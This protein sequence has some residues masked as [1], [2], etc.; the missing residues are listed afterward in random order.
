MSSNARLEFHVHAAVAA[1]AVAHVDPAAT[2]LVNALVHRQVQALDEGQQAAVAA[3]RADGDV[4]GFAILVLTGG[5]S[6][7]GLVQRWAPKSAIDPDGSS[8]C[9]AQR[10]EHVVH[11]AVERLDSTGRWRVVDAQSSRGGRPCEFLDGEVPHTVVM[12]MWALG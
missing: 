5:S 6:A 4:G 9:L 12:R 1:R 2:F 3:T 10:V 7:H 8:P 11:E